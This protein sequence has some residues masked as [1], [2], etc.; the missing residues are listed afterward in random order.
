M[1][2][3]QKLAAGNER[4]PMR[5]LR[6]VMALNAFFIV[7]TKEPG[8]WELTMDHP[9]LQKRLGALATLARELGKPAK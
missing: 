3:L 2:A 7:S 4:I 9:P 5:D 1:S 8:R 6:A